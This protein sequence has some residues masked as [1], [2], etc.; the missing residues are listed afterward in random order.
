MTYPELPSN[1]GNVAT[2]IGTRI[3]RARERR[4][5]SQQ[6]LAD[7]LEVNRKTVDNW[8][9]GRTSPKSSI[10]ALEEVLGVSLDGEP[11]PEPRIPKS[12]YRDVMNTDGLTPEERQAVIG[13]IER[14]LRGEPAVPPS[15]GPVRRRPAS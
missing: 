13:A 12:L 15:P 2:D 7:E 9:N 11:E 6:R 14:T 8:E 10:G 4:R 1:I 5:W 3:K